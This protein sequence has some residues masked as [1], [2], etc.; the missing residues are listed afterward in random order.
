ML[1]GQMDQ[2]FSLEML[3]E[4]FNSF[5]STFGNTL[6]SCKFILSKIFDIQ[7]KRY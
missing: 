2:Y 6:G 5:I 3:M 4:I 1:F 7:F